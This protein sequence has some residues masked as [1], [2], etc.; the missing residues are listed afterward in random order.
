MVHNERAVGLYQK[1][2]FEIEGTRKN[3]LFVNGKYVDE[4]YMA[5]IMTKN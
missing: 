1:V 5:L 3:S 4:Y 2:G